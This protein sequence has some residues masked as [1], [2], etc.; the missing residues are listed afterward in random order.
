MINGIINEYDA[1]W[2][3]VQTV[4]KPPV[5]D[6]LTMTST[7]STGTPLGITVDDDGT[8]YYADIGIVL[9][10]NGPAPA[11]T[12]ALRRIHAASIP[13]PP[14]AIADNL[15]FPDRTGNLVAIG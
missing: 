10:R 3:F 5:G 1:N 4:V 8:L 14:G 15:Q 11:T 6:R 2:Q 12:P 13:N 9:G 7:Y